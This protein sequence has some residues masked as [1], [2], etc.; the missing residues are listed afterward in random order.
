[1]Q[2]NEPL[3][4]GS[5]ESAYEAPSITRL[6][7]LSELTLGDGIDTADG[8]GGANGDIGSI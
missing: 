7:S 1:M 6:G 5:V 2:I 3:P 4:S 8:L